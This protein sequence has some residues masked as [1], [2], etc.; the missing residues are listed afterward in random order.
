MALSTLDCARLTGQTQYT[1]E[2]FRPI[3][4]IFNRVRNYTRASTTA[5]GVAWMSKY[6]Y[7]YHRIMLMNLS[8]REPATEGWPLFLYPPPHLLVGY[9]YLVRTCNDYVFDTRAYS[10]LKY[11]EIHLPLQQKLN[12]TVM[13]NCSYTINT[14]AYHRFIDL[15]NFEETLAQVQQAILAERVVA[16]LA[17][18]RPLRG[19]GT[20]RMGGESVPVEGL[21]QDHYKNLAQCQ[22]QAWGLADR[23]RVQRAGAKDLAILTTI[24]KLKTAFFNFLVT[25]RNPHT[26]LSLPCDCMWL[27]AFVEKFS[28][29]GLAE[30]QT[31]RALPSQTV[32][33][34]IIS[35]LSLP[36]PAPCTPLS[37]GAFELRPRENGRAVT[38]EMR[39][40]RG[41]VIERFVDRLPGRRRRRRA[42]PPAAE[43]ISDV[44]MEEPPAPSP[45]PS[46]PAR[47]F[48][49]E[50]RDTIV[51]VIRLLQEELTVSARNE[52]FF[53]FAVDFYEVM[54]RLEMLG[55]INELTI[56]RWVMYFF[57]AEHIATTLNYLH[58]NLRL[59]PP[60]SR[61]VDLELAQVVMRARDAE[62]QVV[63]SRVWNEMGENAFTQVME[64]VSGDLSATVERAGM[65]ELEEDEIEQFMADIAYHDNSGD[66]GEILRQVAVND[67]EIDSMELSFRFKMTGPVVF[68]QNN[69]IQTIN[70][71]VIAL[72]SQL[73]SQHRPLPAPHSRVQLPP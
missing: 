19:F 18:L 55:N 24:R 31:I 10:R 21:L 72:A 7:Q 49:E 3:R 64:R 71:R 73:K 43:E 26:V 36:R 59:Y 70:R 6:V 16:D 20:T 38:E 34:S 67:T 30:F 45:S 42:P 50:V 35:A 28:D 39:R 15:E 12:W 62:G 47:S 54:Q 32:T 40:R 68:S 8:P 29:P 25:P 14:G 22:G 13:A 41:E 51:E 11:T 1:I 33:K 2:V 46:P 23:V 57:V 56:R 37:G 44:E 63:Y 61:W 60:C 53:N 69:Q 48:E 9:Q 27:D 17:M 65:G 4:N 52:Q 66:V 58:H 5:V